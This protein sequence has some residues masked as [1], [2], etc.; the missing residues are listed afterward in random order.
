MIRYLIFGLQLLAPITYVL[1]AT[2]KDILWWQTWK[3]FPPS[4]S[5]LIFLW[6]VVKLFYDIGMRQ[7]SQLRAIAE[8]HAVWNSAAGLLAGKTFRGREGRLHRLNQ[9]LQIEVDEMNEE[10]AALE[11]EVEVLMAE[12]QALVAKSNATVLAINA[13]VLRRNEAGRAENELRER[14]RELADI[15]GRLVHTM[16]IL[17]EAADAAAAA[18]GPP[19]AENELDLDIATRLRLLGQRLASALIVPFMGHFIGRGLH[20]WA[21]RP[22]GMGSGLLRTALGID[23]TGRLRSSW[24]MTNS[25][26]VQSI[27]TAPS[28]P[29]GIQLWMQTWDPVW[30]AHLCFSW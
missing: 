4:P 16:R 27:F 23:P 19:R 17:R 10:N 20:A 25:D 24:T 30:Y 9:I 2:N 7:T 12:V 5:V 26:Q 15:Q 11:E 13:M 6:P 1:T 18:A 28:L 8:E 22:S 14:Q 29:S 21:L 3:L